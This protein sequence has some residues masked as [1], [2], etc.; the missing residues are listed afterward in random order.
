MINNATVFVAFFFTFQFAQINV[1]CKRIQFKN[2]SIAL[3]ND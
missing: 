2:N 3:E 1:S